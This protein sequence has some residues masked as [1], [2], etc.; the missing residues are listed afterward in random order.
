MFP[1]S[2][3][4]RLPLTYAGIAFIAALILGIALLATLR[5]YYAERERLHLTDNAHAILDTVQR[6][7]ALH[8]GDAAIAEQL[9]SLAFIMQTRVRI[10][11]ADTRIVTDTG[12]PATILSIATWNHDLFVDSAFEAGPEPG[13]RL[14]VESGVPPEGVALSRAGSMTLT[15]APLPLESFPRTDAPLFSAGGEMSQDVVMFAVASTP[16]G[17]D[18]AGE[19]T[20]G[21]ISDQ[22]VRLPMRNAIGMLT[23]YIELSEGA[24][25]GSHIVG[26]V[27]GALVFAGVVAL[28]I[29][30]IIGWFASRRITDPV[31]ALTNGAEQMARGKLNSR[32][33]VAAKDEFGTLAT[34]FNEMAAQVEATITAL[35]RFVADAAHELHTPLTALRADLE[36]AATE[37]DPARQIEYVRRA[38]AQVR[39]LEMLTNNL[40]DLSRLE[41]KTR[42]APF[43]PV[44]VAQLVRELSEAYA[45]RAEQVG[46]GF[47]LDLPDAP[48]IVV[49]DELQLRR[50]IG[51]LLDNAIKFTP[52]GGTV[53]LGVA[54]ADQRVTVT[55]NDTGI[56]I[57]ADDLPGLFSRFHRGRNAAAYPGSGLGLAIIR[58]IMDAHH[59]DIRVASIPGSTRFTLLL[60]TA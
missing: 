55:V 59:G 8:A 35:R 39:R 12:S 33:R 18:L 16:Y 58:A 47:A 27:A 4:W 37:T 23:G 3:R 26:N 49:G 24:S 14:S 20:P 6:L 5:G 51:N 45:S 10:L 56:G 1:Q 32:V 21:G 53:A 17:F 19:V 38:H 43:R 13:L 28:V 44:N 29:A 36:L 9:R 40:L 30:A 48:L 7:R 52:E 54:R 15:D 50:A 46:V 42:S 11:D 57:P 31:L 60:P 25:L 22:V 2:I 41:S 34:T